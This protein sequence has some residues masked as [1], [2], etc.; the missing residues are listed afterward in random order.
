MNR[1]EHQ[2][3][4][5][6]GTLVDSINATAI[7]V[8]VF[9]LII[10]W[11]ASLLAG[12]L[13]HMLFDS[14]LSPWISFVAIGLSVG[15]LAFKAAYSTGRTHIKVEQGF[16]QFVRCDIP[17][18]DHKI[19][20]FG[21]LHVLPLVYSK[22]N[23]AWKIDVKW[24]V[25]TTCTEAGPDGKMKT[26]PFRVTVGSKDYLVSAVATVRPDSNFLLPLHVLSDNETG[27][28]EIAV[29]NL[30]MALMREIEE[31]F[32]TATVVSK[33]TEGGQSEMLGI[34]GNHK[35][36]V[37]VFDKHRTPIPY[38]QESGVT[39]EHQF[40]D[41]NEVVS[42]SQQLGH[43]IEVEFSKQDI[44]EQYGLVFDTFSLGTIDSPE[45]EEKGRDGA[46]RM[47][48]MQDEA[49]KAKAGSDGSLTEKDF[50]TAQQLIAGDV[51]DAKTTQIKTTGFDRDTLEAIKE[52]IPIIASAFTTRHMPPATNGQSNNNS[53]NTQ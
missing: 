2:D 36:T 19:K 8:V 49:R 51:T 4:P 44:V 47:R 7:L 9:A 42:S 48:V 30:R 32:A 52:I 10:P 38:I 27:R 12:G 17:G 25:N 41:I 53:N 13:W 23:S 33:K 5:K 29:A 31:T 35:G 40:Q 24:Q 6:E 15:L 3:E 50:F 26:K 22:W 43:A 28:Q 18:I 39:Y 46:N 37:V 16:V 14:K 1:T 21:G 45:E 11:L 34:K 20:L